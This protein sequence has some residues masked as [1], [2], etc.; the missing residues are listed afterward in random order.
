MPIITRLDMGGSAQ[1]TLSTCRELAGR[2]ETL[3][4]NGLGREDGMNA[5]ERIRLDYD[6]YG[7][8]LPGTDRLLC[9]MDKKG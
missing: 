3:C 1:N 6:C 4:A 8:R 7:R 9:G 2:Y 5:K